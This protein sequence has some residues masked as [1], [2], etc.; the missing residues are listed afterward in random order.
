MGVA[1]AMS[2][3]EE[4]PSQA[5]GSSRLAGGDEAV[6]EDSAKEK[7]AMPCVRS[8]LKKANSDHSILKTSGLKS[9]T[10]RRNSDFSSQNNKTKKK[11][12]TF[13]DSVTT[14]YGVRGAVQEGTEKLD[15][16]DESDEEVWQ[17]K[18]DKSSPPLPDDDEEI[19]TTSKNKSSKITSV[20]KSKVGNIW[21]KTGSRTRVQSEPPKFEVGQTSISV[22]KRRQKEYLT[23]SCS[24]V[25]GLPHSASSSSSGNGSSERSLGKTGR[26]HSLPRG[27]S[28]DSADL[29]GT[30]GGQ[31]WKSRLRPFRR[32]RSSTN[33]SEEEENGG[34]AVL[35]KVTSLGRMGVWLE[36][37]VGVDSGWEGGW[38][39][40]W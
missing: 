25:E 23:A 20:M 15:S 9:V 28:F 17:T 21:K 24:S 30:G 14:Y 4:D 38:M 33:S 31:G 22:K 40:V 26:S 39:F 34:G 8:I 16:G 37:V 5:E 13:S 19:E 1:A 6:S 29:F 18:Y 11:V 2:E 27:T 7:P 36:A 3:E 10:P 32:K 35:T 12:L